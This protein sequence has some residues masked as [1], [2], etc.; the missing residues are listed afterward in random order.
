MEFIG[1]IIPTLHKDFPIL[2]ATH[3]IEWAAMQLPI[4]VSVQI[5]AGDHLQGCRQGDS[6]NGPDTAIVIQS[7]KCY[8][9]AILEI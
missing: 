1:I 8:N 2:T 9:P 4:R 7:L 5:A 6:N 3:I